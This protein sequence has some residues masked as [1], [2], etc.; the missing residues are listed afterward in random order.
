LPEWWAF[1]AHYANRNTT[2]LYE[3]FYFADGTLWHDLAA[4]LY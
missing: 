2:Y 1:Q 4:P 3:G